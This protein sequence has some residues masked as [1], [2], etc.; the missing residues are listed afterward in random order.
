MKIICTISMGVTSFRQTECTR[1][2]YIYIIIYIY[3][4]IYYIYD[5]NS[6]KFLC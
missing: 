3:I 6:T 1:Q 5:T 4:Y 2:S